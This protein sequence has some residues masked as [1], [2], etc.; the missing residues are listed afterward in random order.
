MNTEKKLQIALNALERI[1][2]SK[3]V[4]CEAYVRRVDAIAVDALVTIENVNAV[5]VEND[6]IPPPTAK[7]A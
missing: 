6:I 7:A 3:A 4:S 2:N 1:A 5:G